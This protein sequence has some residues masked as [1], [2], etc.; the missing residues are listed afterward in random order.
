MIQI[1]EHLRSELTV[2]NFILDFFLKSWW[3]P[4]QRRRPKKWFNVIP[5]FILWL[6][7]EE[8]R[9]DY[10]YFV[11]SIWSIGPD[12][13]SMKKAL[14]R[15]SLGLWMIGFFRKDSMY[16]KDDYNWPAHESYCTKYYPHLHT[17]LPS[18]WYGWRTLDRSHPPDNRHRAY[19]LDIYELRHRSWTFWP[20]VRS[21]LGN[22]TEDNPSSNYCIFQGY[23]HSALG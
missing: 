3:N 14:N 16:Q 9:L 15:V 21:N 5:K 8:W 20:A 18:L 1:I 13:F 23:G 4:V 2:A 17:P 22:E 11:P 7:V 6:V 10:R 19:F 12:K